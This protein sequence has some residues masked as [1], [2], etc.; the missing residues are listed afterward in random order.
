MSVRCRDGERT[1]RQQVVWRPSMGCSHFRIDTTS[2]RPTPEVPRSPKSGIVVLPC[3]F[4]STS[5][6]PSRSV[7]V[8]EDNCR[9]QKSHLVSQRPSSC[10]RVGWIWS[11]YFALQTNARSYHIKVQGWPQFDTDHK[12]GVVAISKR[13]NTSI[14]PIAGNWQSSSCQQSED[15]S[16]HPLDKRRALKAMSSLPST[17]PQ[18]K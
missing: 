17:V 16:N 8:W 5:T 18:A 15:C 6:A 7:S 14:A 10:D 2:T 12:I 1:K 3:T 11:N 9:Q 13:Y 4:G